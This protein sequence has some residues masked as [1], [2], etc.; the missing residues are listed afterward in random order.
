MAV[1]PTS[2]YDF[3]ASHGSAYDEAAHTPAG[4]P[5]TPGLNHPPTPG[6]SVVQPGVG[7]L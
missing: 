7:G 3:P 2:P 1:A 4:S 6:Q 5:S